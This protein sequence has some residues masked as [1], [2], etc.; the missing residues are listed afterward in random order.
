[1]KTERKVETVGSEPA[2][3][4]T[5]EGAGG[6]TR[7]QM[8]AQLRFCHDQE[9][10]H[11]L[12]SVRSRALPRSRW[13]HG[14]HLAVA[15]ALIEEAQGSLPLREMAALVRAYN[16]ATGVPNTD[17]E[18]YHQTIT[19]ASLRAVAHFLSGLPEGLA[20]AGKCNHL[21]SSPLADKHWPLRYWSR[22][23]LFS[24][25]ARRAWMPPNLLPLPF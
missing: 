6:S 18:G 16:E 4:G 13:T 1:M 2:L 9:V 3:S 8:P 19:E 11:L 17:R 21:Q 22:E 12:E 24:P 20:L 15:A 23:A 5:P 10:W 7:T 14:A 25:E